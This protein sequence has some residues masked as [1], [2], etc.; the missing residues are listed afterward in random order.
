GGRNDYAALFH[1]GG[2][3][4][5]YAN[6]DAA[7]PFEFRNLGDSSVTEGFAF[8]LEHLTED[9]DWLRVVLGWEDVGEYAGYVRTGKLIFL[10]R[11]AAKLAYELELHAGA[12]PLAEMPDRYARGLSEAVGVDWPRLTYLAD[13]DQGYY[14]AS[15]LRAWALETRL[16]RLLRERFGREWFT[17]AD[18][19]DFL[20]SLWRRGQRLDADELLD[21]VSGERLDFGVMVEEVLSAD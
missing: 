8:L 1:E 13:V 21:E 11:Y 10:R 18:A 5:H 17:R 19:G 4:E 14:A 3:A 20:R 7:L 16:R 12:R 15:Y 2:H 6:V 9:P